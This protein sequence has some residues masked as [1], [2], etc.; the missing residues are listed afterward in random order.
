AV[1]AVLVG[2]LLAT[3]VA[4]SDEGDGSGSDRAET[5]DPSGGSSTDSS[6]V[7]GS[8]LCDDLEGLALQASSDPVPADV[9][10]LEGS[11]DD[12]IPL[13]VDVEPAEGHF[14]VEDRVELVVSSPDAEVAACLLRDELARSTGYVLAVVEADAAGEADPGQIRFDAVPAGDASSIG[15][16]HPEGYRLVT[17]A[18]SV[19]IEAS[20]AAG[21]GWAVQTLLQSA[22]P[23]VVSP[24]RAEAPISFPA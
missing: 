22:A 6:T 19:V 17:T 13:P 18:E 14:K 1:A 7:E 4:C 9:A 21:H 16:A 24:F 12:L 2:A 11:L 20:T 15:A 3:G 10:P 5:S 23:A 8:M